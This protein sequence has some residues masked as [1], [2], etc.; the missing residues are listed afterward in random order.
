M[1][2]GENAI[3][4]V[5]NNGYS[6]VQT[7]CPDMENSVVEEV[8]EKAPV[9]EASAPKKQ[10][11]PKKEASVSQKDGFVRVELG[12][13]M[14]YWLLF[15]LIN[16]GTII[17]IILCDAEILCPTHIN[18]RG[19]L[20]AART[21]DN[22]NP[23]RRS[24]GSQF[25]I[26]TG[27]TFT[28]A[29]LD[30]MEHQARMQQKQDIFNRLASERRDTIMNLRR[31]RD[32]AGLQALQDSL[33][34]LTEEEA[35]QNPFAYSDQQRDVYRTQGGAPHLDGAYTVFG[36]VLEGLDTVE[37]IE[38]AATDAADRPVDDVK[39]ISMKVLE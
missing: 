11:A 38:K 8:K 3:K 27:R 34:K 18:K 15:Y 6:Q 2:I 12:D 16:A 19:A 36:E 23:L 33:V 29:Q 31:N 4:R 37:A 32:Q 9:A 28:D 30:Q 14:P 20:A 17:I 21:G 24:S 22:V 13:E 1:P 39:I 10:P 7:S 5:K 35:A 25:Y 26:V